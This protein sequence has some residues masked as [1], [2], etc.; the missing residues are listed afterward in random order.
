[1]A[2]SPMYNGAYF[3]KNDIGL[4]KQNVLWNID[5]RESRCRVSD[6]DAGLNSLK[7]IPFPELFCL[8]MFYSPYYLI[9]VT[10]P[11]SPVLDCL[12]AFG[13]ERRM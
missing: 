2:L 6:V 9:L 11:G 8:M 1:M 12:N 10:L 3:I 7:V 5:S 4:P 13:S